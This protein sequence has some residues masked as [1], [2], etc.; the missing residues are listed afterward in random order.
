MRIA[1]ISDTHGRHADLD[2]PE[3]DLLI[4]AGDMSMAGTSGQVARFLSWFA[5]QPAAHK[6]AIPGNHDFAC[7]EAERW[8]GIFA[9]VGCHILV[10]DAMEIEGCKLWGSPWTPWFSDWAFNF[11]RRNGDAQ[12]VRHWSEIPDD[13]EILITH[14]PPRGIMDKVNR[15]PCP[16]VG[17]PH[18]MERIKQLDRLKIHVFGH[19]HERRGIAEGG[20]VTYV[21]ASTLDLKYREVRPPIVLEL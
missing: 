8:R 14:G 21:N 4:H 11:P 12:A 13:T 2:V 16:R 6:V 7:E 1:M 19:I 15:V 3:C 5:E 10:G 18:L 20:T 9:G 17:C